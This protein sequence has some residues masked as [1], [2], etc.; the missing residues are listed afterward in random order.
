[1]TKDG[2]QPLT[3]VQQRGIDEAARRFKRD[4]KRRGFEVDAVTLDEN[5]IPTIVI[6]KKGES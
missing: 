6:T 5:W 1:M 3:P 2:E 4:M